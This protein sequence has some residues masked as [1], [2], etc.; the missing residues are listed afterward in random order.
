MIAENKLPEIINMLT[1][2]GE[3]IEFLESEP[4]GMT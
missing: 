1:F 2:M 4:S 3:L